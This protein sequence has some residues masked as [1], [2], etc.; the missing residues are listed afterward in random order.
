[1]EFSLVCFSVLQCFKNQ[2]KS[3][4]QRKLG[5]CFNFDLILVSIYI[6]Y[7]AFKICLGQFRNLINAHLLSSSKLNYNTDTSL[8]SHVMYCMYAKCEAAA[9]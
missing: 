4:T 7:P 3:E 8:M 2:N 1:M 6:S 9:V 5:L